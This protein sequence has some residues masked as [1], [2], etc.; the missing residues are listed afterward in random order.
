MNKKSIFLFIPFFFSQLYITGLMLIISVLAIIYSLVREKKL[1]ISKE[2][3]LI[4]SIPL[5]AFLSLWFSLFLFGE[6][7]I[8]NILK[9]VMYF[10]QAPIYF[11]FGYITIRTKKNDINEV[12]KVV[13]L[14]I[15]LL[16]FVNILKMPF[17]LSSLSLIGVYS[18]VNFEF[19]NEFSIFV[20]L[21]LRCLKF[22]NSSL[23]TKKIDTLFLIVALISL[24]LSFSR[25]NF[26]VALL[27]YFVPYLDKFYL[28]R[29]LMA[30]FLFFVVVNIFGGQ[31]IDTEVS[32][33][34][35]VTFVDKVK[36]SFSEVIV[37]KL[38]T[39]KDISDNWR[40]YEAYM[41]VEK[42]L[43]GNPIQL[44]IGQGLGTN[45]KTPYW[46]FN[47][48]YLNVIPIFHNG[49]ITILLKSGMIGLLSIFLFLWL[50]ADTKEYKWRWKLKP[51]T[52][53][54]AA[55]GYYILSTTLVTH[56]LF[57]KEAPFICLF[58]LGSISAVL[59]LKKEEA[60]GLGSKENSA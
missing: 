54:K 59:Y 7:N 18:R 13:V 35:S 44:A 45:V 57:T 9:D 20:I 36:H 34:E 46:I 58:L 24:G 22:S 11:Y 29:K 27:I 40:G 53:C 26:V 60:I 16:S 10:I 47:G 42:Y 55:L 19:D 21:I 6:G 33:L 50:L 51:Y 41:G 39:S 15:T 17:Q 1:F 8:Y 49:F 28:L 37:R 12:L 23:F 14:A 38:D 5:L 25:T 32:D 2:L 56:G 30:L 4:S 52:L 43:S 31:L 3:I 48:E